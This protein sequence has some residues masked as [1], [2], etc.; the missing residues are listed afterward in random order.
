MFSEDHLLN[1]D[2]ENNGKEKKKKRNKMNP[3]ENKDSGYKLENTLPGY[4]LGNIDPGHKLGNTD[5]GHKLGNTDPGH[6]L[7]NTD[8]GTKFG[9]PGNKL[10]NEN[11]I[12]GKETLFRKCAILA[13][14][15]RLAGT[16]LAHFRFSFQRF[17]SLNDRLDL[18]SL[19][20]CRFEIL[21]SCFNPVFLTTLVCYLKMENR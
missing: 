6:K 19:F 16:K 1:W 15:I 20:F 17:K 7:G 5:P 18:G 13:K 11:K 8:P 10:G 21:T 14:F 2:T 3:T 4:K 12:S 9:T